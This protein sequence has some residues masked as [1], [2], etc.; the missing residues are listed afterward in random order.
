L[1]QC[2]IFKERG[3]SLL[4]R[5]LLVSFYQSH[6]SACCNISRDRFSS[7]ISQFLSFQWKTW[8]H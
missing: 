7:N 8:S 1:R 6:Q 5:I 2:P 4:R 3:W